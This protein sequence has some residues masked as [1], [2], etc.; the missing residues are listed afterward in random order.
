MLEIL[1]LDDDIVVVNKPTG[2][3]VHRT[4]LASDETDAV[5]QR[6]RD[7][8][9]MWVFPVHRLDRGTSGALILALNPTSARYLC[10]QFE[11]GHIKK[12]YTSLVRGHT[13][14]QGVIDHPLATLNEQKGQSRFKIAGTEK[15]AET[16]FV[17]LAHYN[18]PYPVSRYQETRC[19][20]VE[21][22]PIQGRKHQIRRHFKHI[23]HPLMGD[24]RYGCRHHN[25]LFR[26]LE[27]PQRLYLHASEITF[28]HPLNQQ[29]IS[30]KADLDTSLAQFL[31]RLSVYKV[32]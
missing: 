6:L 10:D 30:I 24:T 15:A 11:S 27:F 17:T 22:Q 13:L 25:K 16:H 29:E 1:F 32:D 26:E 8:L 20:L 23:R 9:G 2:L 12:R 28:Q 21:I 18:L 4:S 3:L 31:A 5:V 7:Q 19:S 14:A